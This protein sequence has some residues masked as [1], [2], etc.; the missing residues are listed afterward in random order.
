MKVKEYTSKYRLRCVADRDKEGKEFMYWE[1]YDT[2]NRIIMS[3]VKREEALT[4]LH[5]LLNYLDDK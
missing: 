1:V 4:C 2:K 3:S 5:Y